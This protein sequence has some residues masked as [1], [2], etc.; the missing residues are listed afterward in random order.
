LYYK[1]GYNE[2]NKLEI[3]I[4][5]NIHQK[6]LEAC[7][8]PYALKMDKWHTCET[9]H[10]RA[11]WVEI[12]AGEAGSKLAAQTSTL[13]AAIQIYKKSSPNIRVFPPRFFESDKIAMEDIKRCAELEI[14]ENS[15]IK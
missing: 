6:I 15:K 13:F 2:I 9:T 3:P 1:N 5:E 7:K 10:C 8:P 11:G 4:I 14:E 12:I